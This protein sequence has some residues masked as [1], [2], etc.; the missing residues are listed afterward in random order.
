MGTR[1]VRVSDLDGKD[2]KDGRTVTLGFDGVTREIDLH[3][4]EIDELAKLLEPYMSIGEEVGRTRAKSTGAK[5]G[6]SETS[7]ARAWAL[8]KGMKVSDRGRVSAEV[9]EAYRAAH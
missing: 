1:T 7:K 9:L 4:R 8:S 2:M 5:R 3:Q 6:S